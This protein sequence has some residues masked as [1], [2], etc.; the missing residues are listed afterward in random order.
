MKY[1]SVVLITSISCRFTPTK[2]CADHQIHLATNRQT[3]YA[4]ILIED[5]GTAEQY[6]KEMVIFKDNDFCLN[7]F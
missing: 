7:L 6:G 5:L 2:M 1:L 3:R 4:R